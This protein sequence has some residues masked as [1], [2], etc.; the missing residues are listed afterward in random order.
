MSISK[1]PLQQTTMDSFIAP[2]NAHAPETN[3]DL[4]HMPNEEGD[5]KPKSTK[6][7]VIKICDVK[8]S[9]YVTAVVLKGFSPQQADFHFRF[10]QRRFRCTGWRYENG[11]IEVL[12]ISSR[13]ITNCLTRLHTFD[14]DLDIRME[15]A[16]VGSVQVSPDIRV[17]KVQT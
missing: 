10:L 2:L 7:T 14:K 15:A 13:D 1:S 6:L 8:L 4:A 12:R 11:N 16:P 3:R 9:K 17:L 5:K